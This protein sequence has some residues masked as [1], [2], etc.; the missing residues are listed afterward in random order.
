GA[1]QNFLV[2]PLVDLYRAF[3][4]GDLVQAQRLHA[5]I[6]RVIAVQEKFNNT[7]AKYA[8]LSLLGYDYGHPPAPLRRLDA[9]AVQ[10]MRQE[11]LHVVRPDPFREGRLIEARDLLYT[12]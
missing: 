10:S 4:D 1:S 3:H 8:L 12:E 2:A 11:L 7:A 9:A 5:G 6:A